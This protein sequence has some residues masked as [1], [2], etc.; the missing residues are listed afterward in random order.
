MHKIKGDGGAAAGREQEIQEDPELQTRG[1]YKCVAPVP[2]PVVEILSDKASAGSSS[3]TTRAA[4][5]ILSTPADDEDEDEYD[6]DTEFAGDGGAASSCAPGE[7]GWFSSFAFSLSISSLISSTVLCLR[8]YRCCAIFCFIRLLVLFRSSASSLV[9]PYRRIK[10]LRSLA[11]RTKAQFCHTSSTRRR[12]E[13]GFGV[14]ASSAGDAAA[15]AG[16]WPTGC[17]GTGATLADADRAGGAVA[18]EAAAFGGLPIETVGLPEVAL[19]KAALPAA[20]VPGSTST[21]VGGAATTLTMPAAFGG[22]G[23]AWCCCC[24]T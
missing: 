2:V 8:R 13:T 5:S 24:T 3:A 15:A 19:A 7:C 22:T 18:E 17:T 4:S 9:S 16:P 11:P 20:M 6:D 14:S 1:A 10:S 21:A 23:A 12:R